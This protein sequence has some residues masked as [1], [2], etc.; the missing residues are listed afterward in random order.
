MGNSMQKIAFVMNLP[1]S[2]LGLV[3]GLLLLPS[4]I[5][6]DK[7]AFVIVVRARRLWVNEVFL[8][9]R[10]R[11]FTLGN[12]VLLS[13]LA[14]NTT[15]DHEIVHVRQFTKKP[16]V[17][18]ILYCLEFIKNGYKDNKYEKKAYRESKK[19]A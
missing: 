3:Y 8:G 11:G 12:T 10:V 6:I 18:P 4:S 15:Y 1:W 2:L 17:F 9:W 5:K 19:S 7:L 14:D 13:N 16:F